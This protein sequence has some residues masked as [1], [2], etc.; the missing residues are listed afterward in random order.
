[1]KEENST[2][3][4]ASRCRQYF[5]LQKFIFGASDIKTEKPMIKEGKKN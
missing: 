1:M 4:C 2:L 5:K 3:N